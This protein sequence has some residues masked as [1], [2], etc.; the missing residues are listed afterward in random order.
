MWVDPDKPVRVCKKCHN[1]SK[2]APSSASLSSTSASTFS[3]K[4]KSKSRRSTAD[5][6]LSNSDSASAISSGEHP[7][8]LRFYPTDPFDLE[9]S[10]AG[11]RISDSAGSSLYFASSSLTHSHA[12]TASV[13]HRSFILFPGSTPVEIPKTRRVYETVMNGLEKIGLNYPKGNAG[14]E[15]RESGSTPLV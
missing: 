7:T 2:S 10:A 5:N 3:D 11:T 13:K 12:P 6:A 9:R 1:V 15:R 8:D 4:D 14:D